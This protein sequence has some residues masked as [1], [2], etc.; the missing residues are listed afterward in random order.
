MSEAKLKP[1][2]FCG[3]PGEKLSWKKNSS[4]KIHRIT[5]THCCVAFYPSQSIDQCDFAKEWNRRDANHTNCRACGIYSLKNDERQEQIADLREE[6]A[7]I[8]SRLEKLDTMPQ[9]HR[10][11]NRLQAALADLQKEGQ[12]CPLSK[13]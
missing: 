13:T 12:Q 5:C 8:S 2:P 10:I 7:W 11:F 1:C 3:C 9:R 4:G 6:M